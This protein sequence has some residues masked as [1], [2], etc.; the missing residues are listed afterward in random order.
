MAC[1]DPFLQRLSHLES[2]MNMIL[3]DEVLLLDMTKQ[4]HAS[5]VHQ[6]AV[7]PYRRIRL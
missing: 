7:N 2:S 1:H 6:S 3:Q 4:P 5:N